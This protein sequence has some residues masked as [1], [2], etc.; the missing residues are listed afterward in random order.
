M[1]PMV[2]GPSCVAH[3][4]SIRQGTLFVLAALVY[5]DYRLTDTDGS[6]TW[7]RVVQSPRAASPAIHRPGLAYRFS[8]LPSKLLNNILHES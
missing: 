5:L 2:S 4:Q 1:A 3:V 6:D 8:L 7:Q